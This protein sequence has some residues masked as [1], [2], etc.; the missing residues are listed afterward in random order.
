[1]ATLSGFA[2]RAILPFEKEFPRERSAAYRGRKWWSQPQEKAT[3]FLL[4]PARTRTRTRTITW[5][6]SATK[7]LK[8]A[9]KPQPEGTVQEKRLFSL[10]LLFV[11][12]DTSKLHSF[13][14][15]LY[16][17]TQFLSRSHSPPGLCTCLYLLGMHS[18]QIL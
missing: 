16:H 11:W 8:R 10:I 5:C 6:H 1:M 15:F 13:K 3:A 2:T 18:P 7:W 17:I 14:L 9:N 12:V 4:W